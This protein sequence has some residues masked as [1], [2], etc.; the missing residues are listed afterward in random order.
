MSES[1]QLYFGNFPIDERQVF[2]EKD[3][4][5]GIV[6]ISPILPDHVL[7]IPTST[8]SMG[9][10]Q[11]FYDMTP[12]LVGELYNAV[13]TIEK[14]IKDNRGITDFNIAM[15]DGKS[16]GQ[17]VPHVHVHIL[18]RTGGEFAPP[19]KVHGAIQVAEMGLDGDNSSAADSIRITKRD[20]EDGMKIMEAEAKEYRGWF[21]GQK[22]GGGGAKVETKE[23]L[24]KHSTI[25]GNKFYDRLVSLSSP[26]KNKTSH[27]GK[28]TKSKR[29]KTK[30]KRSIKLK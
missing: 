11:K 9:A 19:D 16:A 6:N 26:T 13:Y 2:Y 18:P 10:P 23:D 25:L 20:G 27:G 22:A 12:E 5:I 30:R 4:I 7:V 15:Q 14:A 24:N 29:I 1:R 28:K 8:K 17:S 21:V 3:N